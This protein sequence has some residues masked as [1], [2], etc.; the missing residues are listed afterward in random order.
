[1]KTICEHCKR[2]IKLEDGIWVDDSKNKDLARYC[3]LPA[4]N[5]GGQLH[6][7]KDHDEA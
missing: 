5:I 2:A 7:V 3:W 6:G 1:M 4:N